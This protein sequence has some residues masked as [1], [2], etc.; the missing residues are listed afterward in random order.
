M[1]CKKL[2]CKAIALKKDH[3]CY[4]HSKTVTAEDKR[5]AR[6]NGGKRKVITVKSKFDNYKLQS[7]KD[8]LNL[9]EKLINDVLQNDIDLRIITGL[10]YN[11][12]LQM[13]LISLENIEN[14][15]TELEQHVFNPAEAEQKIKELF[16]GK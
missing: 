11:L 2:N 4:M 3:Y 10:A 13:R 6:S 8:I 12:Q 1:R 9:N 7:F 5:K 14:R 16:I 15:I